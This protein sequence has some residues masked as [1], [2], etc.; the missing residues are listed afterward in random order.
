MRVCVLV[1]RIEPSAQL[2]VVTNSLGIG[3]T[4]LQIVHTGGMSEGETTT[5]RVRRPDSERLKTLAKSQ[6]TTVVEVVHSAIG[7]LERQEFLRGLGSDYRHLREN[8]DL[9]QAYLVERQEWDPLV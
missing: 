8:S 7:A 4:G 6:Q 5:V 1:R 3:G 9:W 2:S